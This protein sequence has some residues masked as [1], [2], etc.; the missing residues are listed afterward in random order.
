MN[1][2]TFKTTTFNLDH[3]SQFTGSRS[4]IS[5]T[6]KHDFVYLD[7]LYENGLRKGFA[8]EQKL[9]QYYPVNVGY[10][11]TFPLQGRQALKFRFDI[12]NLL[13]ENY[14]I[15]DGSGIGVGAPQFGARRGFYAGLSYD[16]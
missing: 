1:W 11:H 9:A 12:V 15:R 5:Y 6:W 14:E 10:E 4:G 8:N 2:P 3:D 16:F 7:F 13:D